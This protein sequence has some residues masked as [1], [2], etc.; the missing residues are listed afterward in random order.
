MVL[1]SKDSGKHNAVD[2]LQ[3]WTVF[4]KGA[5]GKC[6]CEFYKNNVRV[7]PCREHLLYHKPSDVYALPHNTLGFVRNLLISEKK[8]GQRNLD[9]SVRSALVI[10]KSVGGF[11]LMEYTIVLRAALSL[12]RRFGK[13]CSL[14]FERERIITHCRFLLDK[15]DWPHHL[16]GSGIGQRA[17]STS[18]VSWWVEACAI[19]KE[20]SL[21]QAEARIA[22]DLQYLTHSLPW[23]W[24][25]PLSCLSVSSLHFVQVVCISLT[26]GSSWLR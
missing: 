7:I 12:E 17:G 23:Y 11:C 15:H 9:P 19:L 16:W 8:Q 26:L 21:N 6:C 10:N 2:I 13:F 3:S 5:T 18:V 14:Q 24:G 4:L 20:W 22:A 1:D 25:P